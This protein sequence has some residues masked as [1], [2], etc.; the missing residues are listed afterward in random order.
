MINQFYSFRPLYD[1]KNQSISENNN[2]D[3]INKI[4]FPNSSDTNKYREK[5]NNSN[6]ESSLHK[7]KSET[8]SD[9]NSISSNSI[10]KILSEKKGKNTKKKDKNINESEFGLFLK[11]V[12]GKK[13]I[14][15]LNDMKINNKLLVYDNTS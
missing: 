1:K 11:N 4:S 3:F 12:K 8:I 7:K 9:A 6:P 5:R 10:M 14:E 2:K 13:L 15:Y